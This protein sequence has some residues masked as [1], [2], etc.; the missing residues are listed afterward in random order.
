MGE[1]A[2][3]FHE[4]Y[5]GR[6]FSPVK[7][8]WPR[9]GA[10]YDLMASLGLLGERV[11]V[12]RPEPA[13]EG[14]LLLA[15]TP[16]YVARVRA[17]DAAGVGNLDGQDTPA[18]PGMYRRAATAVGGTLLAARMTMAGDLGHA[19]NP[20]G[21]L[22]HA[23]LDRAS[24]FCIF[25][26]I[27]I[28]VRVLQREF[29][30]TRIAVVDVDGHHGDG[31]Q[32]L[33]YD[34]PIL[35]ISLHQ[36]DGRF[37]PGTGRVDEI[38]RGA[39]QGYSVNVPLPRR[40][41][42]ATYLAAFDAVVPQLLRA[43]RPEFIFVQFGTDA[44]MGDPLVGLSLTTRAYAGL[45]RRFHALGHELSRGRL[46]FLGGGGYNPSS[47]ARCWAILMAILTGDLTDDTR[48]PYVA[49]LDEQ[50]PTEEPGVGQSVASAVDQVRAQVFPYF[51]LPTTAP[52]F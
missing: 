23:Q 9:Y 31:T 51:G 5:R 48:P 28:A 32:A 22:H 25:N 38:G 15:H 3:I 33:L 10:G 21:G 41:G 34:E 6:G 14:E 11:R 47:V 27:V 36:Y 1:V 17:A 35:T 16:E 37:Y 12:V 18:W 52:S 40:V 49:L 8:S 13:L 20:A 43:Y 42:D 24:G 7:A 39:G 46:L 50:A 19:F 45:A 2:L 4:I 26:D 29:G 30:L 44:H